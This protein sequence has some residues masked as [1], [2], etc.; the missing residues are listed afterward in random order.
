MN[1][2]VFSEA[3]EILTEIYSE[4]KFSQEEMKHVTNKR[5]TK[6]VYG[7]LDKH[8]EL[9]Y[10]LDT[11][12]EKKVKPAVRNVL[13]C[14]AYSL[15]YLGTPLNVVLNETG[16]FLENRGKTALKG[17]CYAILSKISRREYVL[18][19]KND[20]NYLEVKYNMPAFLVG[21]FRKDY[22][23]DFERIIACREKGMT[24]IRVPDKT[25]EKEILSAD[26]SAKR[27]ETG[28]FVKNNKEISLL[29]FEG[30]IT[31]MSL[32][33][34]LIAL[35]V[36]KATPSGGRILDCCAAPGGKSV[37]LA[38]KG[39]EV[40]SGELRPHRAELIKSYAARMGV[41]LETVVADATVFDPERA[42]SFDTVLA[43]VPCSGMGVIGRRKD[44]VFNKTYDDIL[45]L[46]ELQYAILDN[47][48]KYVKKGGL[49]VYSTCTVFRKENHDVIGKFLALHEDFSLSEIPLAEKNDGYIQFLPD[50]NGM[51]G[52]F[53]CHLRKN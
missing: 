41:T 47:V 46:S 7:V 50:G 16:A 17:F 1:N 53:L 12:A 36:A 20:K 40:T 11:L 23:E 32:P 18:P 33:S 21:L 51:E 8:Y 28:F 52:F 5:V 35:S 44:V 27:T 37:F 34:T 15:I 45:A 19:G 13:L 9:N 39:F 31:Y 38:E 10:I 22:P 25:D 2:S 24:H 49:L 14:G 26:P 43:D 6:L 42:D 29:N 3:D 48:S 30:K 4:G